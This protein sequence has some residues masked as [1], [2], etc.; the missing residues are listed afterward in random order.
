VRT[1][2]RWPPRRLAACSQRPRSLYVALDEHW[3]ASRA[4]V[5]VVR[6][7]VAEFDALGCALDGMRDHAANG[8]HH[9]SKLDTAV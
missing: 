1:A 8:I 2:G 3:S 4:T 5:A 9:V 6:S 7:T